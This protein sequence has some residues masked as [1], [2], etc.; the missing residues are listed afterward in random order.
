M[1]FIGINKIAYDVLM[2]NPM[3]GYM[4]QVIFTRVLG[5]DDVEDGQIWRDCN[6]C[7]ICQKWKKQSITFRQEDMNNMK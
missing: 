7:W 2:D 1:M 6:Q 4:S 3:T 5:H